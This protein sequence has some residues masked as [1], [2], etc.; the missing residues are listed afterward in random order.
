MGWGWKSWSALSHL[1]PLRLGRVVV[2]HYCQGGHAC[3]LGLCSA[4]GRARVP[5][6]LHPGRLQSGPIPQVLMGGVPYSCW[7]VWRAWFPTETCWQQWEA[8]FYFYWVWLEK[9]GYC[10]K[11]YFLIRLALS[12]SCSWKEARI[13]IS[14][15]Q[16][17]LASRLGYVEAKR[18]PKEPCSSW[19][20]R[21][22]SWCPCSWLFSL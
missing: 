5:C 19:I 6:Y 4:M 22:P 18:K 12:Q 11:G 17:C 16:T 7:A 8:T 10:Q 9:N 3:P 14:G 1:T 20:P 13:G 2:P 21:A 15:L